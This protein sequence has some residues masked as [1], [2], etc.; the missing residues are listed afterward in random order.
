VERKLT[1]V[2][3]RRVSNPW[4]AFQPAFRVTGISDDMYRSTMGVMVVCLGTLWSDKDKP[5][6][7]NDKPGSAGD[8]PWGTLNH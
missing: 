8:K 6:S 1:S 3:F 2:D 7:T 4:R 5:G